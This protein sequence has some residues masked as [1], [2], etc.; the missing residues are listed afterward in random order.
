[1]GVFAGITNFWRVLVLWMMYIPV[2]SRYTFEPR[3]D[4]DF[5]YLLEEN[6]KRWANY[7]LEREKHHTYDTSKFLSKFELTFVLQSIDRSHLVDPGKRDIRTYFWIYGQNIQFSDFHKFVKENVRTIH[8][9][10]YCHPIAHFVL[11]QKHAV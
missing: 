3:V 10:I 5:Q 4:I 8:C 1:M 2:G 11:A 9:A 7:K 6:N